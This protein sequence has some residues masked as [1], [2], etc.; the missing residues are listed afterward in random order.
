MS[1]RKE[2]YQQWD[3]HPVLTWKPDIPYHERL[4]ERHYGVGVFDQVQ[5]DCLDRQIENIAASLEKIQSRQDG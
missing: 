5:I 2:G 3:A 1:K 4:R